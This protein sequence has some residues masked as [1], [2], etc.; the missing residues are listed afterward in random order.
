MIFHI[1]RR[2]HTLRPAITQPRPRT[3]SQT[4]CHH[5]RVAPDRDGV[6]KCVQRRHVVCCDESVQHLQGRGRGSGAGARQGTRP[7]RTRSKLRHVGHTIW[8]PE[9]QCPGPAQPIKQTRVN[10]GARA[11]SRGRAGCALTSPNTACARTQ[12]QKKKVH[13]TPGARCMHAIYACAEMCVRDR[14]RGIIS[15]RRRS[16]RVALCLSSR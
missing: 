14:H 7:R 4:K 12:D 10:V 3:E 5:H 2:E 6:V 15:H 11:A 1:A 13:G 16:V 8:R 9:G